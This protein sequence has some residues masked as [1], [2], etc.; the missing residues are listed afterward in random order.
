MIRGL[1]IA[2]VAGLATFG[3]DPDDPLFSDAATVHFHNVMTQSSGG[4]PADV[5]VD[6]LV[7]GDD[8]PL[9]AERGYSQ[10]DGVSATR[11]ALES[12]DQN[13]AMDVLG[14]SGSTL[15]N[16]PVTRRLLSDNVY[17]LV[18]MGDTSLD[19]RQLQSYRQSDVS[20]LPSQSRLRF[21]HALS[22]QSSDDITVV[23]AEDF[24]AAPLA[25]NLAYGQASGYVTL[26]AAGI[27]NVNVIDSISGD[28]LGA[29]SCPVSG[30]GSVDAIVAYNDFDSDQLALYCQPVTATAAQR[31]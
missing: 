22:L 26:G 18:L 4:V 12:R 14:P 13:V 28:V 21:I 29:A 17:T 27:I 31:N 25:E 9:I 16:G 24:N 11:V 2:V 20:L 5:R 1:L 8:S 23:L 30:G 15:I 19:N 6:L 3:C 10:D 7:N